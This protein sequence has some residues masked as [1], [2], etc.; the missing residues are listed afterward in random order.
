MERRDAARPLVGVHVAVDEERGLL[1]RLAGRTVRD[2]QE[3]QLAALGRLAE[4]L[5]VHELRPRLLPLLQE[6]GHLRVAQDPVE[7]QRR[8]GRGGGEAPGPEGECE[9]RRL[10]RPLHARGQNLRVTLPVTS[11]RVP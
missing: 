7:R 2:R 11:R 8:H 4:A 1:A 9:D 3:P 10:R 5:Q 6:R